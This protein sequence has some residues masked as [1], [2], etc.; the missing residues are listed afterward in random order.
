M[1]MY[2]IHLYK[3]SLQC[4]WI[5]NDNLNLNL[6]NSSFT[7][8]DRVTP[9]CCFIPMPRLQLVHLSFSCSNSVALIENFATLC[10]ATVYFLIYNFDTLPVD[11]H[12]LL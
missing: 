11:M 2:E 3:P 7:K 8:W 10:Y 1:M 4:L 9:C 12:G 6:A 5:S